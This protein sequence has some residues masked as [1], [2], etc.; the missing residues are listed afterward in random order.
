MWYRAV[1]YID[2]HITVF[3]CRRVVWYINIKITFDWA[4]NVQ[5]SIRVTGFWDVTPCRLVYMHR[6]YGIL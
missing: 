3:V 6:D 4:E 1:T 2:I 5:I